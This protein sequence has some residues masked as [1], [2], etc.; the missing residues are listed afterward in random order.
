M[1]KAATRKDKQIMTEKAE[2]EWAGDA[3]D[4]SRW[5]E[6]HVVGSLEFEVMADG[7]L[8]LPGRDGQPVEARLGDTITPAAGETAGTRFV[9]ISSQD[10]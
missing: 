5:L 2:F 1:R 10:D 9:V 3:D 7:V 4:L 8:L 6:Q